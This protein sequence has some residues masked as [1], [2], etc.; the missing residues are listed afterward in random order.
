MFL[1]VSETRMGGR[2][3]TRIR[4]AFYLSNTDATIDRPGILLLLQSIVY[5]VASGRARFP[6]Q[7]IRYRVSQWRGRG[8]GK[9][10]G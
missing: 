7:L 4:P 6:V 9:G 8:K 2:G 1:M 10:K 5:R 3:E